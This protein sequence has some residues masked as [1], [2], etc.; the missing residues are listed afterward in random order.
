[1]ANKVLVMYMVSNNGAGVG[2][3][4]NGSRSSGI[5]SI[6][7]DKAKELPRGDLVV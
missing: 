2:G 1:M 4:N 3:N 5:V 7:V 6:K